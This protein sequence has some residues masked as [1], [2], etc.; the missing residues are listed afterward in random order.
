MLAVRSFMRATVSTLGIVGVVV[1]EPNGNE[2]AVR[3]IG[4]FARIRWELH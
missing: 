2:I 4:P 3:E 1:F